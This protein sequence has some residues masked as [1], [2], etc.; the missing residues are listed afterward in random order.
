MEK[1]DLN[2]LKNEIASQKSTQVK[3]GQ[4]FAKDKFLNELMTSLNTGKST[5]TSESLKQ[6]TNASNNM[7]VITENGNEVRVKQRPNLNS[8]INETHGN[9]NNGN[10]NS[11]SPE[12]DDQIF[13]AFANKS[14]RTIAE[15]IGDLS[16]KQNNQQQY[17]QP[18]AP[19][20][21]KAVES[22]IADYLGN[23]LGILLEDSIKSVIL[24]MYSVERIKLVL[25]ENR[26]MIKS[27][28]AE[29]IKELY[30]KQQ[31][32]A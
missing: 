16:P 20:A 15:S 22:L 18:N 28:V 25:N 9:G 27:I 10:G 23:N 4:V 6:I 12:R 3:T 24:E 11:M 1:I 30:N 8:V 13:N 21:N 5:Q 26:D 32:K 19:V 29:V 14:Q 2:G 17:Q 7:Q 31:T